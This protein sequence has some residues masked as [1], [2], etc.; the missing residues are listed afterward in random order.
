MS[1]LPLFGLLIGQ[2]AMKRN[3]RPQLDTVKAANNDGFEVKSAEKPIPDDEQ[4]P[5]ILEEAEKDTPS[6]LKPCDK[7]VEGEEQCDSEESE[8]ETHSDDKEEAKK[9][10]DT[11]DKEKSGDKEEA[12]KSD[13]AG[14]KRKS[15][16]ADDK[17]KSEEKEA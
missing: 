5:D 16:D 9:S 11:D 6:D 1:G 14:D 7:E 8:Q 13:D 4:S 17:K 15:N 3:R 2:N 12:K 10:D